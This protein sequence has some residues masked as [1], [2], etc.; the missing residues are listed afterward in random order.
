MYL[1][2]QAKSIHYHNGKNYIHIS[3]KFINYDPDGNFYY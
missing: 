1:H 2:A 3:I